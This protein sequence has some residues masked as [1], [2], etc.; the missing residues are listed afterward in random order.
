MKSYFRWL[1]IYLALVVVLQYAFRLPWY[2]AVP[3]AFIGAQWFERRWEKSAPKES[4]HVRIV[5]KYLA[6][7]RALMHD[8]WPEKNALVYLRYHLIENGYGTAETDALIEQL[9]G[10]L[11]TDITVKD[12]L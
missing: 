1:A 6:E 4:R 3:G 2:F 12:R 5:S 8:G 9:R 10:Q 11:D 7:A